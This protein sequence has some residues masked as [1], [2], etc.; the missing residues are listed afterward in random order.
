MLPSFADNY[1]SAQRVADRGVGLSL[2]PRTADAAAMRASLDRLLGEPIFA[3]AAGEVRAEMAT[4]PS[5]SAVIQRIT[6]AMTRSTR[7]DLS[8]PGLTRSGGRWTQSLHR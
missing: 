6:A 2:D 7:G 5:P 3:A 4:Q 1:M 8:G